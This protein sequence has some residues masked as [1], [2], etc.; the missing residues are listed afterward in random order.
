MQGAVMECRL[1][2]LYHGTAVVLTWSLPLTAAR[3]YLSYTLNP[4]YIRKQ[5][6]TSTIISIANNVVGQTLV[7]DFV[8]SNWKKLFEE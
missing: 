6:A 3:R 5:D 7:W 2:T 8:R 4:D 1:P